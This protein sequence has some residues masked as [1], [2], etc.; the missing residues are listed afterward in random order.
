MTA[1]FVIS[2]AC[3]WLKALSHCLINCSRPSATPAA[4]E[5]ISFRALSR[6]WLELGGSCFVGTH[7]SCGS[8]RP[9]CI[10]GLWGIWVMSG[11]SSSS[12]WWFRR[13]PLRPCVG[14][15]PLRASYRTLSARY[16][17]G[18]SCGIAAGVRC[19]C[20]RRVAA[21]GESGAVLVA[22]GTNCRGLPAGL[23]ACAGL[24]TTGSEALLRSCFE[25]DA[26]DSGERLQSCA[27][28]AT[29]SGLLLPALLGA[30]GGKGSTAAWLL[31]GK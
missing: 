31:T 20:R 10:T 16:S 9:A 21:G 1:R 7:R 13:R 29:A 6:L 30:T 18:T 26:G 2:S 3:S 14:E 17:G 27:L 19:S 12:S 23:R 5:E 4:V 15:A 8:A 28:T 22:M 25:A 24:A 11:P